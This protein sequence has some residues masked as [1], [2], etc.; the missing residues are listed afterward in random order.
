M[1][2]ECYFVWYKSFN[3]EN[4]KFITYDK[5]ELDDFLKWLK[6]MKNKLS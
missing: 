3:G 1:N 2:K 5:K 4:E 6:F